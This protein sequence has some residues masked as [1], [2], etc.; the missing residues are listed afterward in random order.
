M[1]VKWTSEQQKVI[2]LRNRNILVSAA[3]GSG[4]TAVLVERIISRLTQDDPPLDVD[5]L[6]IV[7]YTE[8]AAAEMKERIGAAVGKLLEAHPGEAHLER[9]ATLIY[10]AQITTIHSFCLSVIR[11]HFHV[12]GIDPGFRI[13]EEGE[14]KL[15]KQ[16]VMDELLE[17]CYVSGEEDF[18]EFAERFGTGRN[19]RKIE[20]II[21]KMYEYSRSYP[22]PERWLDRCAASGDPAVLA[23]AAVERVRTR[24]EDIRRVLERGLKVCET[25][26]GPYM[27]GDMLESDLKELKK[28]AQ[29]GDF[30]GMYEAAAGFTWKRL[31]SKK[32]ETVSPEK[33]EKVKKLRAQAKALLDDLKADYFYVP[34]P[35][36]EKDMEDAAPSLAVLAGLVKKFTALLDEKKRAR[37][38]IDFS[39]MEQFALAILTEEKEGQ[40]VPSA[41][42][43]EYQEQFDEVM[44]DEYQDSN[45][46]QETIL[47]SVSRV[48]RGQN[49]VFMVGDVKQSIYSFRMSRPEL[50]MEKYHTY[51]LEDSDRQRIDLHR[52]FRSRAEVLDSVN[53]I[54]RQLM[55]REL[56]GI[57]YDDRAAL[58]PGAQFPPL[59]DHG[60]DPYRSELLLLD[61]KD[62]GEDDAAQAEARMIA[63]RIHG[64]I[65]D[66]SV[67]DKETETLRRV[68]YSD[69]VILAR[70]IRGWAETCS[71]V[72]GEEGIPA[73]SVS[74]EG[75]FETYE[76]SV[77]LDYLRILDNAR[78]DL[79]LAAVLTSP[80]GGLDA[81]E[82]AAVRIAYPNV[83]F[84]QAAQMYAE[85]K[86]AE[87][88]PGQCAADGTERGPGQHAAEKLRKF[89][90][91]AAYFRRK[92]P[93]TPIHELLEE[94]MEKTGYRLYITA[95]PGG[96]QRAANL[97]M[98]T[99]RAAAFEGT[100]YK[101]LFNFIRYIEQLKKYDVDYGEAGIMDEQENTVRIMSIHK[102]KGLEFP[103]VFVAGL[104][105]NFNT[106]D[107]KGSV[108]LHS[109]WG[110]G[111]D[112]IDLKRRTKTP[113]FLKK[114]IRE[115][116]VLENLAEEMRVLYV[117]L[118]RAKEKLIMT[119]AAEFTEDGALKMENG[120]L[121]PEGAKK[122]LDWILPCIISEDTGAVRAD[123]PVDIRTAGAEE[124]RPAETEIRGEE[125]AED[126]FRHW[127]ASKTE[128]P[129]FRKRLDDQLDYSYP[130]ENEGKMKLKFT[131]SELKKRAVLAEEAGEEM[132]EEPE[133][134]P[135]LPAFMK[136]EEALTGASRGS[137]YHKLMELLDF[138]EEYG[139][140]DGAEKLA[141]AVGHF[142]ETGRLTEEM[143]A[144][145]R[146]R[147]I[148]GFLTCRSGRRMSAAARAGRLY[149]EQPF[150]MAVD[151]CEIYPEDR[152]G[153]KILVQ[154]IIDV[155]FEEADGLT[156]LDYKTDRVKT[157]DELKEKY[158]AQ[159]DYYAEALEKLTGKPVKEKIIY[160][161]TLGE[162]I[163]V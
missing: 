118:T 119:G 86:D 58:Y 54:F 146:S 75:Y 44:I 131:V 27:Y 128:L 30:D 88:R 157:A 3:A 6:L 79:P 150:V 121:R 23:E 53:Y 135:L 59:P 138:R 106:Q 24:S 148:L 26:D 64:L 5:R 61:K 90:V 63:R 122:Y 93:Y 130:F 77:L 103:V 73:Y 100:S 12:I 47:N 2:D 28:L 112:L 84:Y 129:E 57:E 102:S 154:G 137:A 82:L 139:A 89:Y 116:T 156:V 134:I 65:R 17:A 37:N 115:R 76:V 19:D 18:L 21:L 50:F 117:A 69:I 161:F 80:F 114:M 160:S 126:V 48:S 145:I 15:L 22:R 142:R 16:D 101:G 143:A 32:D 34:R 104:G 133:V 40:L 11:D 159:L 56:G 78:Q 98:L 99:E 9:Q 72:L 111:L 42:A 108:L 66:G 113:T 13:A 68:R 163:I 162:E 140:A 120:I 55:Y 70:S 67:Y 60:E 4:K 109:E 36:W 95:M 51:S 33:K 49:N 45:L 152:S 1:S 151:A 8:A 91:Q 25:P 147:D 43:Q 38:L 71:S 124:L 132:Y 153:G 158:Y 110:A 62:T 52:N 74:R 107:L 125:I 20:G 127:D 136:E 87:R 123:A 35:V 41:A 105:K 96:A 92:V 141:G 46:V 94:V 39:D 155:Y 149:R 97:D 14:L 81:R 7:T 10:S 144:C 29:A 31:S 83:P 85:A